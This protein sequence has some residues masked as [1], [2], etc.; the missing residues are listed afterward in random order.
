MSSSSFRN[1]VNERRR[2]VGRVR[3]RRMGDRCL[4]RLFLG[5]DGNVL[6][7]SESNFDFEFS[8]FELK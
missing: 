2:S 5:F 1:V 6:G 4:E 7:R 8:S 3:K